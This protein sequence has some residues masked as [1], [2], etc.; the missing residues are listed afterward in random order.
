MIADYLPKTARTPIVQWDEPIG[1]DENAAV[2]ARLATY[3]GVTAYWMGRSYLGQNIWAADVM[4]PSPSVLRS[5]AKESTLKAVV[6]YSG[7]QHAN[8]VSST[9]HILKLGEQLVAD[10]E[11][12]TMLK[13]VN[14][15]LHPITNPDG[16]QLSMDLAGITPDNILHPGYHGALAAD[17][18]NGQ[19]ET[20][21]VYPES[22]T[23]RQLIEE[24]LPDA[25]LNPHGYP[26][27]EWVQPFSEY[28][29]WVQTREQA[30]PGR[31][32]WIPRGWFTSLNYL[33]DPEHPY[34]MKTA[35]AIQDRIVQAERAVPG[36]LPLEERMN[37]RYE[38]FGQRWQPRN[39]YQPIV[40]GIRIYMSL[41]GNPAR[42][43]GGQGGGQVQAAGGGGGISP[44]ITWDSGYTE[45]PDETAHG[46]Y[47]KLLASAGLA[48]DRVH[49]K[50]LAEGHLR[51]T[52][53]EREAQGGVQW[54]VE[55][56][57]PILPPGE[58]APPA[59]APEN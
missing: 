33:R 20:D 29:G 52:R 17:V 21:P 53:T 18:A 2:L 36:L 5:R 41:K 30:N 45:A 56:A 28:T 6:V 14:V 13:Q 23:R 49:L 57:R 59:T 27:H 47:L 54:R 37:A 25:F 40:D 8:E 10:P 42:P 38:R 9:S 34:S 26:S 43:A 39:M 51:I 22:R 12:R 35:Y 46:D 32:W 19:G 55:R 4:L 3:P 16:A 11:T 24:W 48:F 58:Q 15:V 44:D 1:P 50:Y 7:R 31:A